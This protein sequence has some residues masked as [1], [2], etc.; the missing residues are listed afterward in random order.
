MASIELSTPGKEIVLTMSLDSL[1]ILSALSDITKQQKARMMLGQLNEPA[2]PKINEIQKFLDEAVK[3][4]DPRWWLTPFLYSIYGL[5]RKINVSEELKQLQ[6][7][8][9][10]DENA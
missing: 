2:P 8:E 7:L 9:I 4:T 1:F 10:A 3:D 5:N 6:Q